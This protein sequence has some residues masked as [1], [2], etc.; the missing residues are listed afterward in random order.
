MSNIL[1]KTK[2][3]LGLI[4]IVIIFSG[5]SSSLLIFGPLE[6]ISYAT[7]RDVLIVP[8]VI[9][10]FAIGIISRSKF[11]QFTNRLF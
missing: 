3:E 11:P 7:Y 4:I 8:S 6:I 10:I 2:A 9:V 5:V 1:Q